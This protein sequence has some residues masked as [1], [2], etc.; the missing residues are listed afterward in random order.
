MNSKLR[1][2]F[3]VSEVEET[4]VFVLDEF[5]ESDPETSMSPRSCAHS[6]DTIPTSAKQR[7][8]FFIIN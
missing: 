2:P 3:V 7:N 6:V 8:R 1:E 4:V 5:H